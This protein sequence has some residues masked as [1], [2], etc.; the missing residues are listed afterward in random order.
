MN[1]DGNGIQGSARVG[2]RFDHEEQIREFERTM[3]FYH[4]KAMLAKTQREREHLFKLRDENFKK[5]QIL[6]RNFR[7]DKDINL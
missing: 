6:I 3:D 4:Q 2:S 5:A 7:K 1:N